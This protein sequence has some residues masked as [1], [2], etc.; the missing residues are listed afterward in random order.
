MTSS[1]TKTVLITGGS[2]GIGRAIALQ[3]AR[4]GF[5]VV[6]NSAGNTAKAEGVV[7]EI[8]STGGQGIAVQADEANAAEV[9]RL[10][11]EILNTFSAGSMWW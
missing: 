11:K 3:L 7:H 2:R 9:E 4:H 6:V 8:T 10:F 1:P 5:A